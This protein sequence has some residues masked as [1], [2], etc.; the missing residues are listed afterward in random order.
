M[1]NKIPLKL[2]LIPVPLSDNGTSHLSVGVFNILPHIK[3]I[4]AERAK[5][6]RKW[7][8]QIVP[9]V[10]ISGIEV[11]ELEKHGQTPGIK[12]VLQKIKEGNPV[13]LMSEA[14]CP[15]VADPGAAVVAMAHQMHI[16]VVP[17]SGPSSILL[18]LMSSGFNGQHFIFHGYLPVK[19]P[20]LIQ[21]LKQIEARSEREK[22]TQIFI[23]T[24]YR[25]MQMFESL[26]QTLKPYTKLCIAIDING[27]GEW[28]RSAT[29]VEWSKMDVPDMHK[30][31]GVFLISA[32]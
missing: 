11:Y 20:A 2:Y 13:G 8:K 17:L 29:V 10:D 12:A 22:S 28:I 27:P 9:D 18:A 24:P 31:P 19:K 15:G 4:I 21:T 23:E 32:G 25:N 6:A 14:G 30:I 26:L 3:H 7:I 5:T 16:E 1:E